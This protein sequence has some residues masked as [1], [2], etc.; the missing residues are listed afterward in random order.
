MKMP[1]GKYKGIE[2][3]EIPPSYLSWLLQN[4]KMGFKMRQEVMFALGV[5]QSTAPKRKQASRGS[6]KPVKALYVPPTTQEAWE[7]EEALERLYGPNMEC[8]F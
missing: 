8:P 4:V 7:A 5:D 6:Q 3:V 2:M 1:F